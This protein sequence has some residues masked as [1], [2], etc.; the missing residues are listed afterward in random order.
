MTTS[1]R[2]VIEGGYPWGMTL[3]F[4]QA[5]TAEFLVLLPLLRGLDGAV[6][7]VAPWD[8]SHLASRLIGASPMDIE[9]FE[10]TRLHAEGGPT[11][12]SPAVG[13]LFDSARSIVSYVSDGRDHWAK[14]VARLA[15]QASRLFLEPRPDDKSPGHV[16]DWLA[17]QWKA[18]GLDVT[19]RFA[20]PADNPD[21]PIMIHPGSAAGSK[22]WPK[23]R[24]VTL[25]TTLRAAGREVLPVLGEIELARWKPDEIEQWQSELGAT[26]CKTTDTL[27]TVISESSLVVANEATPAHLA[28]QLGVPTLTLFG[29]SSPARWSPRGPGARVL[30]PADGPATMDWL[31]IDSVVAAVLG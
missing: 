30:A 6:V 13:D 18:A 15:P 29:P 7:V 31:D 21:R 25:M 2:E 11:R 10:F 19:P 28:A 3:I 12:V 16:T 17:S 24:F 8:R 4:H 27:A 9:M 14:N 26:A 1:L 22:C 20:E 5:S 23:D